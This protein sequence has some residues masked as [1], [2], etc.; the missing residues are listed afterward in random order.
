[1]RGLRI[2]FP[3]S[4]SS[5]RA[6]IRYSLDFFHD[7]QSTTPIVTLADG[8]SLP[9]G[10][11]G[12]GYRVCLEAPNAK[13]FYWEVA[14]GTIP[15]GLKLERNGLLSGPPQAPGRFVFDVIGRSPYHGRPFNEA[16]VTFKG[17]KL[18]ID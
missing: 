6:E 16:D 5:T 1:V 3:T 8:K 4:G 14:N 2:A 15:P 11:R 17:V 9:R 13:A 10:R 12:D 18:V 7:G